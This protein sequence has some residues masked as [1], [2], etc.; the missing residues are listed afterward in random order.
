M[1]DT[2]RSSH[3]LTR[4]LFSRT[5]W[6]FDGLQVVVACL[7]TLPAVAL[8]YYMFGLA[9]LLLWPALVFWTGLEPSWMDGFGLAMYQFGALILV[10][11]IWSFYATTS[12]TSSPLATGGAVLGAS[13]AIPFTTLI[14]GIVAGVGYLARRASDAGEYGDPVEGNVR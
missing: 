3:A 1:S 7:A 8:G 12:A 10:T 9:A 5:D 11:P 13:L 4:R 2:D 6:Q 14:A